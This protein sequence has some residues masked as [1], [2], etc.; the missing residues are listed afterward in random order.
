[1]SQPIISTS[2][3][4]LAC[5]TRVKHEKLTVIAALHDLNH[6]AMFCDRIMV[7]TAGRLVMQGCPAAVFTENLNNWFGIDAIVE[8]AADEASCFIRYQRPA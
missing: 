5:L 1:M 4:K 6:A 7:M 2:S 8:R 3:I